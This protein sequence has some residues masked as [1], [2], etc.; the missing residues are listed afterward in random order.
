M[1]RYRGGV[2]LHLRVRASPPCTCTLGQEPIGL[3]STQVQRGGTHAQNGPSGMP[4]I[5]FGSR[6]STGRRVRRELTAGSAAP[7]SR[8]RGATA[9]ATLIFYQQKSPPGRHEAWKM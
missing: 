9:L 7:E 3:P 1:C 6:Q 5:I 2:S 8:S 4:I